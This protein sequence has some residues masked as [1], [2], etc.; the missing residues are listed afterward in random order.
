M[1]TDSELKADLMEKI[2][3]IPYVNA[4]DI[5][6]FVDKGMVT[7]NGQVDTHQTRFQVERM[8]RRVPGMRGLQINIKPTHGI[9]KKSYR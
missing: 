2:D 5:E 6:V 7:L 4:E 3:A 8:A 1:R 9:L